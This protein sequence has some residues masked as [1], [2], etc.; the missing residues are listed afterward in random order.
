MLIFICSKMCTTCNTLVLTLLILRGLVIRCCSNCLSFYPAEIHRIIRYCCLLVDHA[1]KLYKTIYLLANVGPSATGPSLC[2][3]FVMCRS[4]L[5]LTYYM[6]SVLNCFFVCFFVFFIGSGFL[7]ASQPV[8]LR[9]GS[10]SAVC[11]FDLGLA[12]WT[13]ASF[14]NPVTSERCVRGW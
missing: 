8:W 6:L 4:E 5:I 11:P 10:T 9:N 14:L 7:K 2:S 12:L 3:L 1:D 13:S